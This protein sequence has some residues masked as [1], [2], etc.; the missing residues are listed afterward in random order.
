MQI[1]ATSIRPGN[2]LEVENALWRVM[3]TQHVTPGKG[4]ACM[5]VEMRNIETGNKT[6]KRFNSTERVE[7]VVLTQKTMQ[8]LYQ[9]GDQYHLMDMETYDQ[10]SLGEDMLEQ[11]KAYL[12]PEAEVTVEFH[13]DRPLNVSL[14]QSV[15]LTVVECDAVVKGQTA[16]GSYKPGMLETGASILVPPYLEPGTKVRVNT[17]SGEF[18][19]RA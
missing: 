5:Q 17:E 1:N 15:V 18:M 9:E 19:E 3:K 7:R 10:L 14:P 2:I 6:N 11:A 12:L 8:F 16:T 4:V 13:E